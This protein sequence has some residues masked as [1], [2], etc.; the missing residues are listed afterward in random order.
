MATL[1]AFSGVTSAYVTQQPTTKKPAPI[2]K[3]SNP[4]FVRTWEDGL[5]KQIRHHLES[6]PPTYDGCSPYMIGV[7][8]IPGSGK[9]TS[10][11]ILAEILHDT[12][13]CIFP[14]DGYH[15]SRADLEAFENPL[16]AL[17]RRGAPDTFDAGSLVRDL[18]EIRY[19]KTA[20]VELP[21]FDHAVGD[22]S[23]GQ[24]VFHRQENRVVICEGLY[25]LH[26]SDGWDQ[27]RDLFDYTV[28]VQADVDK[29]MQRLKIRNRVIPG[30]TPE[31]IDVRVDA[32]D[33]ENAL[34]V[35]RSKNRANL[36]VQSAA[37]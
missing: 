4:S 22:P 12:G 27:V 34:M 20:R 16:D 8:G 6:C 26:G 17:Y 15:F 33:R 23:P 9:S 30:Y 32:V 19:G 10:A 31:E 7:C 35:E 28:F 2:K 14:A 36:V 5:E 29:C 1:L 24:H 11:E 18:N 37:A 25:L 21:G 3:L 13:A